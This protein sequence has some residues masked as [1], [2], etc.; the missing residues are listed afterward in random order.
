MPWLSFVDLRELVTGA[1][2]MGGV[3]SRPLDVA[4]LKER[5]KAW[6]LE[7]ALYTSLSIVERLFPETAGAVRRPPVRRCAGPPASC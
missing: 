7:R 2:F 5:A 1:T 4:V 3:Y 6:R